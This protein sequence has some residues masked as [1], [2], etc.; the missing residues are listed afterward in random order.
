MKE[1][2]SSGSDTAELLRGENPQTLYADDARHWLNIYAELVAFHE[3]LLRRMHTSQP[4]D[5]PNELAPLRADLDRLRQRLE[6]WRGRTTALAGIDFDART[7]MLR[8]QG[9]EM[10]L[11]KRETQLLD[12]MLRHPGRV[13][14]GAAL[15][16]TAW[17]DSRLSQEQLRLYIVRLRR[18]LAFVGAPCRIVNAPQRGYALTFD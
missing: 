12:T 5:K 3:Q 15:V 14:P 6:F 10:R 9:L 17:H 4:P 18:K 8:H 7:R 13:T 11:T 16:T 1:P 2:P